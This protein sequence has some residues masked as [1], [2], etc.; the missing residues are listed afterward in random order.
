MSLAILLNRCRWNKEK[1]PK[2]PQNEVTKGLTEI[3]EVVVVQ[4]YHRT[5]IITEQNCRQNLLWSS[6]L[7]LSLLALPYSTHQTKDLLRN[8]ASCSSWPSK[9]LNLLGPC[10]V[11]GS[12]QGVLWFSHSCE[13]SEVY[14]V[15][16]TISSVSHMGKLKHR[17]FKYFTQGHRASKLA[18]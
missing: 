12:E 6:L 10:C 5:Q 11:P 4:E 8:M 16:S 15:G 3:W 18:C 17:Q 13:F 2:R 1:K 14:E 9:W 7:P